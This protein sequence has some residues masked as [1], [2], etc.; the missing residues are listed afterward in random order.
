MTT[1]HKQLKRGVKYLLRASLLQSQQY[2]GCNVTYAIKS[3]HPGIFY[4]SMMLKHRKYP[5][6]VRKYSFSHEGVRHWNRLPWY[7]VEF[8]SLK[9]KTHSY[10][11]LGSL[12]WL[13]PV[14]GCWTRS[15]SEV[16][17]QPQWFYD[18]VEG[19][20]ADWTLVYLSSWPA[21]LIFLNA[22]SLCLGV[23]DVSFY[24]GLS[25]HEDMFSLIKTAINTVW[26]IQH[27]QLDGTIFTQGDWN[28]YYHTNI[29]TS[30]IGLP[31]LWVFPFPCD[32]SGASRFVTFLCKPLGGLRKDLQS[33]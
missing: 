3:I 31:Y 1:F 11:A 18:S 14:L 19:F 22:N 4:D 21:Y 7:V 25:M 27:F 6:I 29:P 33:L 17:P 30:H 2:L 24:C 28:V 9:F 20:W 8:P 32:I 23:D 13:I 12:T 15:S 10:A 16:P 5:L 26:K